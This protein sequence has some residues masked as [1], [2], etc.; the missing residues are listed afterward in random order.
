MLHVGW[1]GRYEADGGVGDGVVKGE[2]VGVEK[3]AVMVVSFAVDGI[4][5]DGTADVF[6]MDADLV[7][8]ACA[9]FDEDEAGF[10]ADTTG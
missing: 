3:L 4:A 6:E 5:E 9:G 10:V 1:N 8:A 7:G 2:A